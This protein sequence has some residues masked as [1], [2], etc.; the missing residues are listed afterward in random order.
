M[1]VLWNYGYGSFRSLY[2]SGE[3][4]FSITYEEEMPQPERIGYHIHSAQI[5]Q[6]E[7]KALESSEVDSAFVP[8]PR[9]IGNRGL[10]SMS[11]EL[12]PANHALL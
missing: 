8:H 6:E 9:I 7:M 10:P 4:K 12:N 11:F 2:G 1:A 5:D 3:M